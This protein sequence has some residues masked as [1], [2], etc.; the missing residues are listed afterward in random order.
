M[1]WHMQSR[2]DYHGSLVA[3][4]GPSDTISTQLRLL[5]SSSK[6]LILPPLEHFLKN[7][8]TDPRSDSKSYILGVHEACNAR[9]AMARTF[10]KDA[11]ARNKRLVF[12]NGGTATAQAMC[13]NAIR[14]HDEDGDAVDAEAVFHDL[15]KNGV[16]GLASRN[17]KL[18]HGRELGQE[19]IRKEPEKAEETE[20]EEPQDPGSRAM[21]AAEA[22]DSETA[23]LQSSN[24]LDLTLAFRPRSTSVPLLPISDDL[25]NVPPFYVFGAR[26]YPL[27]PV[28]ES[29]LARACEYPSFETVEGKEGNRLPRVEAWRAKT[30][31]GERLIDPNAELSSPRC[32]GETYPNAFCSPRGNSTFV[33]RSAGYESTPTS[34]AIIG[35]ATVVDVRPPVST[36]CKRR[37]KPIDQIYASA[38]RNQDI[39]LCSTSKSTPSTAPSLGRAPMQIESWPA[40]QEERL[41][42]KAKHFSGIPRA[43]FAR[44]SKTIIRR[45]PPSPLNLKSNNTIRRPPGYVDKG[46]SPE[47]NYVHRGTSTD[48]LARRE[49][50]IYGSER[51]FLD[52]DEDLEVDGPFEPVLPMVE[53]LVIHFEGEEFDPQLEATLKDFKE[54]RY[55]I[56]KDTRS[57][58]RP[59]TPAS[60]SS[61]PAAGSE[62]PFSRQEHL[63]ETPMSLPDPDEYDPF[64]SHGDYLKPVSVPAKRPA[65]SRGEAVVETPPT[66]A[67]TPEPT[68]AAAERSFHD[69]DTTG[70][71]TAVCVQNTLRSILNL[72]FSPDD[73]G[74]HQF[75]FP[76]LPEL[77][78]LWKPIFREAAAVAA[79]AAA[80]PANDEAG[81]PPRRQPTA[82]PGAAAAAA[83]RQMDLILAIGA[84]KGVDREFLGA[85]AGGLERL[86]GATTRGSG[87][88]DLRYL[89]A[90]AMQAF[91][92]QPLAAQT[93]D[94]PFASPTLLAALLVP[95]LEAYAAAHAGRT[96]FLLLEYPPEH[97][98][99]VLALQ[100]LVGVDLL[101]V[102]GIV[103]PDAREPKA[104]PGFVPRR[105]SSPSSSSSSSSSRASSVSSSGG[106]GG[107]GTATLLARQRS[108]LRR[109]RRRASR[110][111][112]ADPPGVPPAFARAN[113]LLT[114]TATEDEIATLI[115]TIWR[116]LIEISPF[117]V[118]DGAAPRASLDNSGSNKNTNTKRGGGGGGGGGSRRHNRDNPLTQSPLLDAR[119]TYAPLASA[120]AMLGFSS[121]SSCSSPSSSS[122]SCC[123]SSSSPS[124]PPSC[125]PKRAKRQQQP[126][127]YV[128][129]GTATGDELLCLLPPAP[130]PRRARSKSRAGSAR[131]GGGRPHHHHHHRHSHSK[132]R[133]KLLSLMLG[134]EGSAATTPTA[135]VFELCV[136]DDDDEEEE[137]AD[138]SLA[139]D[140][141]RYMPLWVRQQVVVGGVRPRE[142]N[143]QKALKFLGLAT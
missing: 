80:E 14:E 5:P 73:P 51:S 122:S 87:R 127:S 8:L 25:D 63:Q 48:T 143:K 38:I 18:E 66:P 43:T 134:V 12:L 77:S 50:G 116:V 142:G 68:G 94:S 76:L 24:E 15:V 35:K 64:A 29:E 138:R 90:N 22:L 32:V 36:T 72:Y 3:F 126:A 97:L 28:E 129:A 26:E 42:P 137:E 124:S 37:T 93:R 34:P 30:A 58:N 113:F 46:T 44:P 84:Q 118:P 69:F 114:S 107:N 83:R 11:T 19:N 39:A 139:A 56:M 112:A 2:P 21:R 74:Y 40:N 67:Q 6:I 141:R 133:S 91:T 53:D 104:Y 95:H 132:H 33:P 111:P 85:V 23:S 54:G 57:S 115:A 120:A 9:T 135:S 125:D 121:P 109:R 75:G 117:Y 31:A 140:E 59:C 131:S 123:C 110:S 86:G 78:S 119:S 71:K 100:R 60:R 79:A 62:T 10:L 102:A 98:A 89:V 130:A 7:D 136:G 81:P 17:R 49:Y 96:R 82:Q 13:I 20:E 4:E 41:T 70:C 99:T 27:P 92:A 1:D 103:D 52:L 106:G 108:G 65:P 101:K 61:T 105:R 88:L 128:S 45:G 55:P 47:H 16:A